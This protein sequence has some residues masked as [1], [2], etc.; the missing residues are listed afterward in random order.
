MD[1][2]Q[3]YHIYNHANGTEN[4]FREEENYRFFLQQYHKYLGQVVDT[5][6]FCLMPNH[7]HLLVGVRDSSDLAGF[8]NLPGLSSTNLGHASNNPAI[9]AF[10][11]FFNS[12]TKSFN[13]RFQ[14]RGSLFVKHF[15][16]IPILDEQQWQETFGYIH[17]NP[18]K[19]G[20]VERVEDW[21]WS[22]W[23][24]YQHPQKP[25]QLERNYYLNFF[26]GPRHVQEM[27]EI[28]KEWLLNKEYE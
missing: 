13:R 7:F 20:F 6:A 10:S 3:S 19:H 14:R 1:F 18:M 24:S 22:S 17:L 28:K 12:Y 4:I 23:H 2:G 15:K 5:Y 8:K 25:S 21:K 27:M 9:K 16:K 11:D 26:D